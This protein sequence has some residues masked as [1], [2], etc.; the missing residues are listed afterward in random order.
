MFLATL[1]G[2]L[3]EQLWV[4]A[5]LDGRDLVVHQRRDGICAARGALT[6]VDAGA[7][8]GKSL[9]LV[10]KGVCAAKYKLSSG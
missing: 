8:E 2:P 3:E 9:Y 10:L 7:A 1:V 4:Q 5:P 6:Q